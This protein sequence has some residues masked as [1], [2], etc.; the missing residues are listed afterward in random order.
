MESLMKNIINNEQMISIADLKKQAK[1][2]RKQNNQLSNHSESLK[3][4]A[5]S[6]NYDS[7]EKLLDSSYLMINQQKPSFQTGQKEQIHWQCHELVQYLLKFTNNINAFHEEYEFLNN[8]AGYNALFNFF[9]INVLNQYNVTTPVYQKIKLLIDFMISSFLTSTSVNK[10]F[11]DILNYAMFSKENP[12]YK[13]KLSIHSEQK[14]KKYMKLNSLTIYGFSE[15]QE[16][17]IDNTLAIED[18]RNHN[19][20]ILILSSIQEK[21]NIMAITYDVVEKNKKDNGF[22][23]NWLS[24]YEN[25]VNLS[26][27]EEWFA[28]DIQRYQR[29]VKEYSSSFFNIEM[30]KK[31]LEYVPYYI[32]NNYG[33][34]TDSGTINEMELKLQKLDGKLDGFDCD[35]QKARPH[36]IGNERNES[37]KFQ[38]FHFVFYYIIH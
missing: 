25:L 32:N 13:N 29:L 31:A 5:K 23:N 17:Q 16:M 21:I 14:L 7:W 36:L 38:G 8:T 26:Q 6:Y 19:E 2:A 15:H 4:V 20:I 18:M 37:L 11:K 33:K 22:L 10:Q 30:H 12:Y 1:I 9:Q 34:T 24:D 28:N 35:I 27:Y 3:A